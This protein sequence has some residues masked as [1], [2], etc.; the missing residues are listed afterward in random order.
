MGNYC[1]EFLSTVSRPVTREVVQGIWLCVEWLTTLKI[2]ALKRKSEYLYPLM[3][4]GIVPICLKENSKY[5]M[6]RKQ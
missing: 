4:G 6:L 3:L 2:L 1:N 5:E